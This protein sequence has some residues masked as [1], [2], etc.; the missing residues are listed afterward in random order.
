MDPIF[1]ALI[2]IAA[3]V[4]IGLA[5]LTLLGVKNAKE[6]LLLAVAES[7][8]ALGSG[9]G[10]LKLR[11][12]YDAFMAKFPTLAHVIPFTKFTKLVN[13]ALNKLEALATSNSAVQ[14]YISN[15]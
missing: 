13:E 7:E 6:W 2:I 15:K 4:L 11:Q 3:V 12:V 14:E 10:Q 5:I 8:K 1:I 9:T